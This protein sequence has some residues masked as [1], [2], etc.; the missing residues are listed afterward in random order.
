MT[1][2]IIYG[3]D[4]AITKFNSNQ[5]TKEQKEKNNEWK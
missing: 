4:I 1:S 2:L 3:I 5:K